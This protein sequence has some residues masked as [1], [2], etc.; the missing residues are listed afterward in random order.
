MSERPL[1]R[2]FRYFVRH[3][4]ELVSKYEGKVLVIKDDSV[5][6]VFDTE[7]AALRATA[8]VHEPGTFMIQR[9]EPGP[10]CYTVTFHGY[11][12]ALPAC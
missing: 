6:G 10:A 2:E 5:V 4:D 9:C 7:L 12:V 1:A 8:K 3:Q 11:H